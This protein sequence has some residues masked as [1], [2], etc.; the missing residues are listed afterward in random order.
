M[1][2]FTIKALSRAVVGIRENFGFLKSFFFT[3]PETY[4]EENIVID[5]QSATREVATYIHPDEESALVKRDGYKT[6]TVTPDLLS[7]K[8]PTKATDSVKRLPGEDLSG[9]TITPEERAFE[10]AVMD[11]KQLSDRQERAE[12]KQAAEAIFTGMV[13]TREGKVFDF[14][15]RPEH[16]IAMVGTDQWNNEASNPILTMKTLKKL[17]QMNGGRTPNSC[18]M[19]ANALYDFLSHPKVKDSFMDVRNYNMGNISP[20][21]MELGG[22]LVGRLNIPGLILDLYTYEATYE[23][24][25]KSTPYV[26]ENT[27][28][29]GYRGAQYTPMYAGVALDEVMYKGVRVIDSFKTKDPD[30]RFIR[31]QSRPLYVPKEIDTFGVIKTRVA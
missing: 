7:E 16:Q 27:C 19:D 2:Y 24:K 25:G 23:N 4:Y 21:I 28:W 29:M 5:V 10:L 14:G 30:R 22:E 26:P 3:A 15:M 8:I 18:I 9:D 31:C 17:I 11:A 13:T 1:G 20:Q 6:K 12:E